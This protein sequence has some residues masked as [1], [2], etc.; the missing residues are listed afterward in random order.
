MLPDSITDTRT[1]RSRRLTRRSI[2]LPSLI[3]TPHIAI[4]M[5]TS[6]NSII[7]QCQEWLSSFHASAIT[8]PFMRDAPVVIGVSPITEPI[9]W[10]EVPPKESRRTDGTASD[11]NA[12]P[13]GSAIS[14]G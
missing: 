12:H 3:E 14:S 13:F 11:R 6:T 2:R 10:P 4:D 5:A 7:D 9:A 8:D 1:R